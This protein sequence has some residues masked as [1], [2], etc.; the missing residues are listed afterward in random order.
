MVWP[1]PCAAEIPELPE[2]PEPPMDLEP[3]LLAEPEE[4]DEPVD[5]LAEEPELCDPAALPV[6]PLEPV[7]LAWDEPGSAYA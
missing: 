2:D 4:A 5:V 7:V 3:P 1:L 6:E